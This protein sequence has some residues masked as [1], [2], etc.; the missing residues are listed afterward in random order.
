MRGGSSRTN[1]V[2]CILHVE[3]ASANVPLLRVQHALVH[4]KKVVVYKL[5]VNFNFSTNV[6]GPMDISTSHLLLRLWFVG[7]ATKH[8]QEAQSKQH[9]ANSTNS[10]GGDR[11][12]MVMGTPSDFLCSRPRHF[13]QNGVAGRG[14]SLLRSSCASPLSPGLRLPPLAL[15]E[16]TEIPCPQHEVGQVMLFPVLKKCSH[17]Y[18]T[19]VRATAEVC[20]HLLYIVPSCLPRSHAAKCIMADCAPSLLLYDIDGRK[21]DGTSD[22]YCAA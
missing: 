4:R 8:L 5:S 2:G 3:H 21:S 18:S 15:D 20:G 19:A 13:T 11:R 16:M 6:T 17:F 12:K 22:C 14:L 10:T 7:F 9:A 1:P